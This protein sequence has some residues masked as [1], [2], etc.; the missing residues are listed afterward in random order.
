MFSPELYFS[1]LGR[2][3]IHLLSAPTAFTTFYL[4]PKLFLYTTHIWP[5][6][7]TFQL[8]HRTAGSRIQGSWPPC[9][10][11]Q[12]RALLRCYFKPQNWLSQLLSCLVKLTEFLQWKVEFKCKVESRSSKK[13]RARQNCFA[14]L[15]TSEKVGHLWPLGAFGDMETISKEAVVGFAF[16]LSLLWFD[17]THLGGGIGS[18]CAVTVAAI[19]KIFGN[20]LHIF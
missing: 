17:P 8:A 20:R 6:R 15:Q 1:Q 14:S 18:L 9:A 5:D 7:Q 13:R 11:K 4:A 16:F 2:V 19:L 12:K 3:T 10:S